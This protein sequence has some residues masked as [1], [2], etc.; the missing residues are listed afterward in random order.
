[1]GTLEPAAAPARAPAGIGG[2]FGSGAGEA[3]EPNS[4]PDDYPLPLAYSWSML[5]SFWDPRDRYREQLRHAENMLAFLGSI[6]AIYKRVGAR[7]DIL[8]PPRARSLLIDPVAAHVGRASS[9]SRA[10]ATACSRVIAR[11]SARASSKADSHSLERTAD[12]VRS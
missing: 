2:I 10:Y 4:I 12:L 11:P 1:M 9:P 3:P 7:R 8:L 6:S 5:Q